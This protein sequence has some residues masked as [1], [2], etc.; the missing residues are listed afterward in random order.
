MQKSKLNK[1]PE[2]ER[3]FFVQILNFLNDL[4]ALQK[5]LFLVRQKGRCVGKSS[6]GHEVV[7]HIAKID[8]CHG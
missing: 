4:N 2:S 6:S 5:L 7:L 8:R 3:L 1:L